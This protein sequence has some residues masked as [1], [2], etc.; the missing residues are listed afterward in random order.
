MVQPPSSGLCRGDSVGL[1]HGD[2]VGICRSGSPSPHRGDSVGLD[3]LCCGSGLGVD[4]WCGGGSLRVGSWCSGRLVRPIAPTG[5]QDHTQ[6]GH[7]LDTRPSPV[8]R[9]A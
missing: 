3:P 5:G 2:T 9:L 7:H 4:S 8:E 1:C 6:P